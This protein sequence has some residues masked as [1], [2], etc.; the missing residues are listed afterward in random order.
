[1]RDFWLLIINRIIAKIK[2]DKFRK[3]H[4]VPKC[5]LI[6]NQNKENV[7]YFDIHKFYTY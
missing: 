3:N 6:K 4:L 5:Q 7:F 1:M 2:I